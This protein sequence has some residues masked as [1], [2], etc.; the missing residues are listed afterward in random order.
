M[1]T[2]PPAYQ[3]VSYQNPLGTGRVPPVRQS[4][5]GPNKMCFDCF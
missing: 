4:V 2:R 1:T 3:P 5:R